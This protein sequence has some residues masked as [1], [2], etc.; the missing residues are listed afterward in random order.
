[1]ADPKQ[2]EPGTGDKSDSAAGAA[3][4][5][6]DRLLS[7]F[8]TGKTQLKTELPTIR[9]ILDAI[10]PLATFA[11]RKMQ[12]EVSTAAKK[13]VADAV[14]AVKSDDLKEVPD[15]VVRGYL[16]DRYVEDP[17]FRTAY[18]KQGENPQGW[19]EQL[20]KA[21]EAFAE[22][23]KFASAKSVRSDV[24]AA[25]AAVKG[26]GKT[27]DAKPEDDTDALFAMSGREFATYKEKL[28]R[29]RP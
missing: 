18:D 27:Q 1:M 9:P 17:N 2:V 3:T 25:K 16:Q 24:E 12:E 28:A 7:E 29:S 11:Q 19:Q 10:K 6:V 21:R 13:S 5:D 26:A 22:D 4:S 23:M 20:T 15:R 14:N 8:E